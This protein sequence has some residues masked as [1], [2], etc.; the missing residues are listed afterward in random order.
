MKVFSIIQLAV[1]LPFIAAT[2]VAQ[3]DYLATED[4]A[5]QPAREAVKYTLLK[6][7]DKTSEEVRAE[8]RNPF[9]KSEHELQSR[10]Q[11][12][13]NEENQI[14]EI[15]EKLRV[16]G[17]TPGRHG[18]RVM[19][20]DMIL[21]TD[22]IVPQVLPQ[23]TLSLQVKNITP[24]AID[25]IWLEKKPTGLPP[26]TLTIAVD[27][28]PYV[29]VK[30]MGQPDA[31]NRW[32]KSTEEATSVPVARQFPGESTTPPEAPQPPSE[33]PAPAAAPRA[34][35]PPVVPAAVPAPKEEASAEWDN[36]MKLLQK[37][38]PSKSPDKP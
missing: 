22:Q 19:L 8:E 31:K 26:R 27:L 10:N 16:V 23:Q 33:A 13:T 6:P 4:P 5:Q 11:K 12:G 30:L 1:C 14:R 24:E 9:G 28:R 18:L 37:L 38:M 25:L 15:L 29:R 2:A 36:A 32:E 3:Q 7:N 21:E 20:G 34:G 35:M 17:V